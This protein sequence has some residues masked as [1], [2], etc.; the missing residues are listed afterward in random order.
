M[1]NYF[2]YFIF[3]VTYP[4]KKWH[5]FL[6]SWAICGLP[7]KMSYW[8]SIMYITP[9]YFRKVYKILLEMDDSQVDTRWTIPDPWIPWTIHDD[10]KK[11]RGL[12]PEIAMFFTHINSLKK[13]WYFSTLTFRAW[14][15]MNIV[16]YHRGSRGQPPNLVDWVEDLG[17]KTPP[18]KGGAD[19]LGKVGGV[20]TYQGGKWR[21]TGWIWRSFHGKIWEVIETPATVHFGFGV[22]KVSH[23]QESKCFGPK[24]WMLGAFFGIAS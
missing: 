9:Y 20:G 24:S 8:I 3:S 13:S 11:H 21:P 19:P 16:D 17:S 6:L 12:E 7:V 5:A 10:L 14:N 23:G 22:S 18:S 15:F 4:A 2:S 1:V